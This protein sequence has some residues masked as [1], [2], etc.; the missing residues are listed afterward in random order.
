MWGWLIVAGFAL[1]GLLRWRAEVK[2]REE[3]GLI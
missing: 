3:L 1:W 2:R